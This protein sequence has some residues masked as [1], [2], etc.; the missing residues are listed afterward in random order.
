MNLH[1]RLFAFIRGFIFILYNVRTTGEDGIVVAVR[2]YLDNVVLM[3][4]KSELVRFMSVS[5]E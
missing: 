2:S 3:V 5:Y 1:L 4:D